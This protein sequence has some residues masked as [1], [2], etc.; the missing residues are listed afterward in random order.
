MVKITNEMLENL[1][2][3]CNQLAPTG[4]EQRGFTKLRNDIQKAGESNERIFS[5]MLEALLV[6]LHFADWPQPE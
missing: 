3:I 4:K 1:H 5:E 2:M 6:G